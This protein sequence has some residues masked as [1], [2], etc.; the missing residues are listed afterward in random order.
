MRV[1][2][3]HHHVDRAYERTQHAFGDGGPTAGPAGVPAAY[4]GFSAMVVTK[5]TQIRFCYRG[6]STSSQ[7]PTTSA[8]MNFISVSHHLPSS[9]TRRAEKG[10]AGASQTFSF[11]WWGGEWYGN[12]PKSTLSSSA[13]PRERSSLPSCQSTSGF[14][15]ENDCIGNRPRAVRN[16]YPAS[17]RKRLHRQT[18]HGNGN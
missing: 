6:I 9:P 14:P 2:T 3:G 1:R 7:K 10:H 18:G 11:S 4:H 5:K 12:T 13:S 16:R 15:P 17:P 8:P